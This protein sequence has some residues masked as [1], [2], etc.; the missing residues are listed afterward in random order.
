M[1]QISSFNRIKVIEQIQKAQ[2]KERIKE[3]DGERGNKAG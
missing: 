1:S 2:G 3:E